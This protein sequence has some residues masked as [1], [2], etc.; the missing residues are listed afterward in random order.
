[1]SGEDLTIV[2]MRPFARCVSTRSLL[3]GKHFLDGFSSEIYF[4]QSRNLIFLFVY[5]CSVRL[6][7]ICLFPFKTRQFP[8]DRDIY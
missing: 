8:G 1:M 7:V 6:W 5:G 3:H 2:G 4:L